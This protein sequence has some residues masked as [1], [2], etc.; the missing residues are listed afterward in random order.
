MSG[1]DLLISVEKV[2]VRYSYRRFP[3]TRD[4]F[5]ALK[6]VSFNLNR[7]DSLGIIGRNGVGKTT[8]LRLL[9][10]IIHPDSGQII[11]YNASTS[12]LSL[13]VGFDPD[14]SG[15]GNVILSGMLLGFSREE[16]EVNLDEI[17]SFSELEDFIDKPIKSYST[18]MK[19][20]LGFSVAWKL[21]PDVLL[22]DEVLGV[23]DVKF[24]KKSI[25]VM[26]EKLL[27]DQTT[28]VF[29]SHAGATV[30]NLCNRVVWIED[31]VVRMVGDPDEVVGE[32]EQYCV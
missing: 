9:G 21:N 15:R 24:R 17:I 32:Y 23:G 4:Y 31:G 13:Q 11:N 1:K 8:L 5:E 2:G 16:V 7:G 6:D 18:G 30:R 29:V 10:G 20:R 26:K 12:L 14:L 25:A 28:I 19:A 3:F 22:I 27:S